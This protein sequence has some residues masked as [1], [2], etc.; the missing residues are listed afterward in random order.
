[1]P[2]RFA[3]NAGT[4]AG[5][6]VGLSVE[7]VI[8]MDNLFTEISFLEGQRAKGLK[9]LDIADLLEYH[10]ALV[11]K[12]AEFLDLYSNVKESKVLPGFA[13]KK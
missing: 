12:T 6:W 13:E 11:A 8:D 5:Q 9:D 7:A 2:S 4:D 3:W 1:V 10:S